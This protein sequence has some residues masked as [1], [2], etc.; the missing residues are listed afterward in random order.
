MVDRREDA[1]ASLFDR[2]ACDIE[3]KM[4]KGWKGMSFI[5]ILEKR[6]RIEH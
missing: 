2:L 6:W 5:N 1:V 4:G 3:R